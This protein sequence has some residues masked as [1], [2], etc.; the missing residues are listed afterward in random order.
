VRIV[1]SGRHGLT[2]IYFHLLVKTIIHDQAVGHPYPVRFHR[3]AS[4]I[5][6]I[7]HI[8]VVEVGDAFLAFASRG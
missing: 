6:I 8:R 2:Y 4:H 3:M 1:A 5:G 7:A